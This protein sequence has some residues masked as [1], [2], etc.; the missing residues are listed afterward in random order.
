VQ[1]CFGA[2]PALYL[3]EGRSPGSP[4]CCAGLWLCLLLCRGAPAAGEPGGELPSSSR[5]G[6]L[7][8]ELAL[9]QH[10]REAGAQVQSAVRS[11]C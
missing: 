1:G 10:C 2:L 3:R 4:G 8:Q 5:A 6:R 7:Q 11:N 9:G